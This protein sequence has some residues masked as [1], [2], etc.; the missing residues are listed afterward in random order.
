MGVR[1]ID[2]SISGYGGLRTDQ[3]LRRKLR[4]QWLAKLHPAEVNLK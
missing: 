4:R 3:N 2:Y 1:P